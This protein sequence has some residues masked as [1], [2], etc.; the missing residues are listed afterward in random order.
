MKPSPRLALNSRDD[1]RSSIESFV[2]YWTFLV[3]L[4]LLAACAPTA[5]PTASAATFQAGQRW[6]M[7]GT[8]A[9]GAQTRQFTFLLKAPKERGTDLSFDDDRVVTVQGVQYVLAG[10]L[11]TVQK[12]VAVATAIDLSTTDGTFCLVRQTRSFRNG[13]LEGRFF[14]GSVEEFIGLASKDDFSRFGRCTMNR[15]AP[16]G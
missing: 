15:R 6:E 10:I 12:D 9:N 2:R 14:I 3:G 11:Y 4:V 7:T 13:T 8:P 1:R 16:Q 5:T